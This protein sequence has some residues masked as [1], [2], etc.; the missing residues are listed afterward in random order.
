MTQKAVV[1]AGNIWRVK[2]YRRHW[3]DGTDGVCLGAPRREIRVYKTGDT[4][5]DTN[6]LV[7]ELLHATAEELGLEETEDQVEIRATV[8]TEMLRWGGV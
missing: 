5:A 3:E 1:I 4:W 2:W 6:T 8:I 7:H